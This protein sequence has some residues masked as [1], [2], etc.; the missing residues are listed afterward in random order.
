MRILLFVFLFIKQCNLITIQEIMDWLVCYQ[1]VWNSEKT[2]LLKG[3]IN[4]TFTHIVLNQHSSY[5]KLQL[6]I[7]ATLIAGYSGNKHSRKHG[8]TFKQSLFL[9]WS[10]THEDVPWDVEN[11]CLDGGN[12]N[13]VITCRTL[14]LSQTHYVVIKW[15]VRAIR[16]KTESSV[17]GLVVVLT[18]R[19]RCSHHTSVEVT[20]NQIVFGEKN[21]SVCF[22]VSTVGEPTCLCV[23]VMV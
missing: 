8:G 5:I 11:N 22:Y 20:Q 7:A 16:K 2:F 23:R 15:S 6:T 14:C 4:S 13:L 9:Q 10:T 19:G 1:R 18:Y 21:H 3:W 12:S 17:W